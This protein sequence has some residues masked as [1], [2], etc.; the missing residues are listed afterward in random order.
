MNHAQPRIAGSL[1]NM[2]LGPH[3]SAT[4]TQ[5]LHVLIVE[6]SKRVREHLG[7]SITSAGRIE[8][9]GHAETEAEALHLLQ[10]V[11][12]DAMVLELQLRQGNGLAVLKWL[13]AR[14][15]QG[16]ITVIVLTSFPF[17]NLRERSLELGAS[18]FFDKATEYD[19]VREVLEELVG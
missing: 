18:Y 7:E 2:P 4:R 6:D 11:P 12:C 19:R 14:A 1:V 9:V 17:Q 15:P 10:N 16:C 5:P 8:I 3:H 13:R